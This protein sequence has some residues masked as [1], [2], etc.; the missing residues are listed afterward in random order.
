MLKRR[1][2][3]FFNY[4]AVFESDRQEIMSSLEQVLARGAY[5]MQKE[6]ADFE[7]DLADFLGIKHA[8]GV[9]DGTMGL[10]LQCV[11]IPSVQTGAHGLQLLG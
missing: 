6:L 3:P 7:R 5:I 11:E 4:P 1:E 8:I 9:G 2:I 10:L